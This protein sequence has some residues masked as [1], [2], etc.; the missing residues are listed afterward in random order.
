MTRKSHGFFGGTM[1]YLKDGERLDDLQ[2]KGLKIIQKEKGFCFGIDAVLLSNFAKLKKGD[3]AVDLGTGTGIIPI[4]L[5]GKFEMTKIY[6]IEIQKEMAEMSSR[7]VEIND[8][9]NTIKI[10]NDDLKNTLN[11]FDRNSIDVV[12][13]NPPY[14]VS[15][16]AIVNPDSFKAISRHEILCNID[17][18]VKI[19]SEL[20]KNKGAFYM[21]HRPSRLVDIIYNCRKYNMEPK[22][23]RFV[24]PKAGKRP[25]IMLIKSVKNGNPELKFLDPLIVYNDDGSYTDEIYKIYNSEKID[26]FD[27]RG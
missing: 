16:G 26:V 18:V 15:G 5:S 21:V 10:I 4:L 27:K 3:I 24:M 7:S 13:S 22:E 14:M 9:S 1:K 8:L 25:N 2:L 12:V 17:D 20:L 11:Y 6:G 19:A 23:I